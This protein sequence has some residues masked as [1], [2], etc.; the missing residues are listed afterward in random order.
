MIRC[1]NTG[2]SCVIDAQGRI[3]QSLRNPDGTP[4]LEGI[5]FGTVNVPRN[6]PITFYM[7][8]G[9]WV[10]YA[11]A[12]ITALTLLLALTLH[13]IRPISPVSPIPPPHK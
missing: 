13:L 4:F 1:A 8:H 3:V 6:P 2:I 9:D 7:R 10:A 12:A 11:S 5:L